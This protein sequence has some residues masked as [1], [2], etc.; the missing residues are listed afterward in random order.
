MIRPGKPLPHA[1]PPRSWATLALVT[2]GLGLNLR[3]S[4]LLSPHLH[5]R[6]RVPPTWY[7]L[8]IG[9]PLLI[10]ALVRLPVG[11]LTDRYGVRVMFPAVSLVTAA[12][13]VG[14][15]VAGSVPL[16]VL[17][18][19]V[20]GL[21]SSVFVVGAS[22]VTSA[23]PYGWRGRTLAVFGL[24]GGVAAVLSAASWCL[25]AQ[26]RAAAFL[27]AGALVT[28]AGLAA[29]ALRDPGP[30]SPGGPG[31]PPPG[32]AVPR[33]RPVSPIRTCAR[34]I[35]LAASSSV[36][37]LYMLALSG[38]GSIAVFLPVY[39]SWA[40]G[41]AWF[42]ALATTITVVLVGTAARLAGGW[43]TDRR[44]TTRLL[45]ISYSL[46]AGLCAVVAVAPHSWITVPAITG[47]AIC[48]GLA[49]G[50]LLALIAKATRP[51]HVGAV[52]G[53][54]SAAGAL[55]AVLPAA[56]FVGLHRV[57]HTYAVSWALMAAML[58]AA[59]LYVH[60]HGLYIGLGLAIE[61]EPE[62]S[63]TALTLAVL[64]G[65]DTR[66]GAAAVV[67]R[68]A[69]L[70]TSDELVVVYGLD[71]RAGLGPE[72]LAAGM[73]DRLPRHC[74]AVVRIGEPP[75]T[76]SRDALLITEHIDAGSLT[77]AVTPAESLREVAADLAIY[78]QADRV[79]MV[80]FDPAE[81]PDLH[82]V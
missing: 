7:V 1:L 82:P 18:G 31:P 16:A 10:G 70:A 33:R 19:L 65:T 49:G 81:G 5:D 56:L 12:A 36:T 76:L 34:M 25:D 63:P 74:V 67:T 62:P 26:G 4:V 14:L 50:A 68:L 45:L 66:L 64:A 58:L 24:G 75:K 57:T 15:G 40:L 61:F 38:L 77:I 71:E 55:G 78:L 59:A 17:Y 60:T 3:A 44:P 79:L 20:A 41:F 30:P 2:I 54:T 39:L 13:V 53:V 21:G 9:L 73:R 51:G 43:R 29:V 35:R 69:E 6:F 11:V 22:Y 23:S 80:S 72:E 8:L 32:D 42:H 46:A 27:L 47:V 28:V 37:L 48:D 52:L